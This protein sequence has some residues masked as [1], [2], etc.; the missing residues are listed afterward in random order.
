MAHAVMATTGQGFLMAFQAGAPHAL[1]RGLEAVAYSYTE[2]TR[3]PA[4]MRWEK[5]Q[6]KRDPIIID[7]TW[8]IRPRGVAVTVGVSTFPTWNGYPS[9]FASL[10]TGNPVIIKP[11]PETILPFALFVE[12]ARH[13]LTDAGFEA[14]LVSLAVDT[15]D[16][17]VAKDLVM[18]PRVG[19][20][21]L[22]GRVLVRR[23]A[24]RETRHTRSY[25]RK[26]PV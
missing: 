20:H 24:R 21:R 6:G 8:R 26:R 9:I 4:S 23:L 7:K 10:A 16:A 5:P 1:D 19:D 3:L 15:P 17:S 25:T 2:M 18:D 14:D 11:H 22:H 13:V 12:T